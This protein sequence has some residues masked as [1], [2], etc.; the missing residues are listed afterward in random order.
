METG[1]KELA[2]ALLAGVVLVVVMD[3][4]YTN[5][6]TGKWFGRAIPTNAGVASPAMPGAAGSSSTP[7]PDPVTS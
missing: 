6:T 1:L 2:A 3:I 7:L 4:A 5:K